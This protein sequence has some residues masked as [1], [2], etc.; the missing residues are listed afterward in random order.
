MVK[1]SSKYRTISEQLRQAIRDSGLSLNAISK[2]TGVAPPVL[3]HFMTEGD[4]HRDI[5]LERTADRLAAYF[6]MSLTKE[7]A[8]AKR[9]HKGKPRKRSG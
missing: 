5:R 4:D 1:T 9:V 6:G 7:A 3:W 2:A 8:P